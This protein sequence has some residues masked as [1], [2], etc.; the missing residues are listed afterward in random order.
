MEVHRER[1]L[2]FVSAHGLP[3]SCCLNSDLGELFLGIQGMQ[4]L[5]TEQLPRDISLLANG[6]S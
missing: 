4:V 6:A 3:E 5:Y 1:Q 2:G